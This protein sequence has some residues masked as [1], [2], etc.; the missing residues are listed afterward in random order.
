MRNVWE[1]P[2]VGGAVGGRSRGW[3]EPWVEEVD[4]GWVGGCRVD[5]WEEGLK[6]RMEAECRKAR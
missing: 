3:E 6:H 4:N 2:W 5:G 1:E